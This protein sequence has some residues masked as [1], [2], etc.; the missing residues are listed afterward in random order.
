MRE[1][2]VRVSTHERNGSVVAG[3]TRKAPAGKAGSVTAA[4]PALFDTDS[5]NSDTFSHDLSSHLTFPSS[6]YTPI[7]PSGLKDRL[8]LRAGFGWGLNKP[9]FQPF[10]SYGPVENPLVFKRVNVRSGKGKIGVRED[11]GSN[12]RATIRKLVLGRPN[13]IV[14]RSFFKGVDYRFCDLNRYAFRGAWMQE[15]VFDGASLHNITFVGEAGQGDRGLGHMKMVDVSF[16]GADLNGSLFRVKANNVSFR[17]ANVSGADF[18][19]FIAT[20]D[21][22]SSGFVDFTD[23]NISESQYESI[24]TEKGGVVKYRRYSP[25]QAAISLGLDDDEMLVLLWAGEFSFKNNSGE[26]VR[27]NETFDST[28]HHI[29]QWEVQRYATKL[30]EAQRV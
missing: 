1:K 16:E 22:N 7:C 14:D 5:E 13:L 21:D 3:H 17:G 29:P 18:G 30:T 25:S 28:V 6:E 11:R 24:R 8:L 12:G 20:G 10:S 15:N 26:K 27:E 23:S 4:K 9:L 2:K 19:S